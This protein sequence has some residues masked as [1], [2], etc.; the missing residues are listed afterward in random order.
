VI[1]TLVC[2]SSETARLEHFLNREEL[3]GDFNARADDVVPVSELLADGILSSLPLQSG[4]VAFCKVCLSEVVIFGDFEQAIVRQPSLH[5]MSFCVSSSNV[6]P[7]W[8]RSGE[9][10]NKSSAVTERALPG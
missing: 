7:F 8:C 6:D 1:A 5:R 3:C 9:L 4:A 2:V 10:R